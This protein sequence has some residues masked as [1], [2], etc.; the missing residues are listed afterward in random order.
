MGMAS[1]SGRVGV[2]M[3]GLIGVYAMQWLDGKAL[4]IIFMFL[5]SVSCFAI[6]LMPYDTLGR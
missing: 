3:L 1:M 2:I 5:M 6:W 4:Y